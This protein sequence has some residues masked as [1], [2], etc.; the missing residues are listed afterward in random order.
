M[1]FNFVIRIRERVLGEIR[2]SYSRLDHVGG[3]RFLSF[4]LKV[5][6]VENGLYN[7]YYLRE[8]VLTVY[9]YMLGNK[10]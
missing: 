7:I 10:G 6:T 8:I 2:V 9:A 5:S 4:V 1:M 3:G